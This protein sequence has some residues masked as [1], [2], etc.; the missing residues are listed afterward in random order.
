MYLTDR[1]C[2]TSCNYI[3]PAAQ[4][5]RP[6]LISVKL[7][8]CSSC[9]IGVRIDENPHRGRWKLYWARKVSTSGIRREGSRRPDTSPSPRISCVSYG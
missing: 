3:S 8:Q 5:L 7:R 6:A 9:V 2:D 4:N 1:S